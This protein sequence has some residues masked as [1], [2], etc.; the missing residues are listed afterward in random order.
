M[1]VSLSADKFAELLSATFVRYPHVLATR[2]V[3]TA[4][5]PPAREIRPERNSLSRATLAR[6]QIAHRSY[7]ESTCNH[8]VAV[9]V[10]VWCGRGPA[11]A[12]TTNRE[13][14]LKRAAW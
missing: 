12:A 2:S 7:I 14:I 5:P 10:V 3:V 9:A 13:I 1:Y 11:G 4:G 8:A 6:L